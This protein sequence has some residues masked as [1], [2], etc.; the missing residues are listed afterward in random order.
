MESQDERALP[1]DMSPGSGHLTNP[2]SPSTDHYS[3]LAQRT[4]A[5]FGGPS[6]LHGGQRPLL[7]RVIKPPAFPKIA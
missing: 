6:L 7:V 2:S 1:R 3:G 5:L 4:T